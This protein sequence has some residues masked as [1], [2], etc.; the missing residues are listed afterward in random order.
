MSTRYMKIVSILLAVLIA[1]TAYPS[2][3]FAGDKPEKGKPN[4][5]R[6]LRVKL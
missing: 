1:N 2:C 4:S 6:K 5:R 3:A